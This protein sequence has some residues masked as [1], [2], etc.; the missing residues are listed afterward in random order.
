MHNKVALKQFISVFI[1]VTII[2][3]NPSYNIKAIEDYSSDRQLYYQSVPDEFIKQEK[4]TTDMDKNYASINK[5]NDRSISLSQLNQVKLSLSNKSNISENNLD[6]FLIDDNSN[7]YIYE[8]SIQY[9]EGKFIVQKIDISNKIVSFINIYKDDTLLAFDNLYDA[10]EAMNDTASSLSNESEINYVVRQKDN[11]S[12]MKIAA[13]NRAFA[14]VWPLHGSIQSENAKKVTYIYDDNLNYKTYIGYKTL[15][16]IND[17]KKLGSD[18]YVNMDIAGIK[19]NIPIS[20]L[21][22]IPEVLVKEG[23]LIPYGSSEL[24]KIN[25]AIYRAVEKDNYK[26]IQVKHPQLNYF[27]GYGIAPNW[28]EVGK[29]YYSFDENYFYF[30]MLCTQRANH[31]PYYNYYQYLPFESKSNIESNIFDEYT[32]LRVGE[33]PSAMK[34]LGWAFIK[35]QAS[36]DINALLT[37]SLATLESG[38]GTTYLALNKNNLF[39]WQAVDSNPNEGAT[40]FSS[41]ADSVREMMEIN[42]KTYTDTNSWKYKGSS[43]G[44]KSGGLA[45]NYSSDS[46]WS[47]IIASVAYRVDLYAG[48]IDYNNYQLALAKEDKDIV[49][50]ST[51]DPLSSP[52]QVKTS[53]TSTSYTDLQISGK[54][55]E[56]KNQTFIVSDDS[57][58]ISNLCY[59]IKIQNSSLAGS[60][61]NEISGYVDKS[62]LDLINEGNNF[63]KVILD[64]NPSDPPKED[65]PKPIVEPEIIIPERTVQ[66]VSDIFIRDNPSQNGNKVGI[67]KEFTSITA[68]NEYAGWTRTNLGWVASE[69]LYEEVKPYTNLYIRDMPGGNRTG[70]I[71]SDETYLVKEYTPYWSEVFNK[72]YT[73]TSLLNYSGLEVGNT[74]YQVYVR[75]MPS[76]AGNTMDYYTTV[77]D[78]IE[79]RYVNSYWIYIPSLAGYSAA[80]SLYD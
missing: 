48:L 40:Y 23:L 59:K 19:G 3:A 57:N 72:G 28:M 27:T 21:D 30:D 62:D 13:A 77:G 73:S 39:G 22:I 18:D 56:L 20:N 37:Y 47:N 11:A 10:I 6:N 26:E 79:Y 61:F 7:N 45:V 14:L 54:S 9:N 68:Y 76:E 51:K 74:K 53:P 5:V 33:N 46:K 24:S 75:D 70:I 52:I 12:L 25:T 66:S 17:Y 65:T 16:K 44:N 58:Q 4:S 8:D 80:F 71:Y 50:R 43:L 29:N 41:P 64:Q 38:S 2:L 67:L 69:F 63:G 60:R 78:D 32:N 34:N 36:S 1:L 55:Q 42:L 31:K 15:G 35:Y 49:I